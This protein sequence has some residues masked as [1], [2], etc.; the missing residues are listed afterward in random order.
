[1]RLPD[2]KTETKTVHFVQSAIGIRFDS[3]QLYDNQNK[4]RYRPTLIQ[5]LVSEGWTILHYTRH[6]PI[7]LGK[8]V[9]ARSIKCAPMLLTNNSAGCLH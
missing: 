1:M 2:S 6:S 3:L 7:E 8:G 4:R 5:M 9:F